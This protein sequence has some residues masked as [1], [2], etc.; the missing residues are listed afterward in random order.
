[1]SD[2][3]KD[4]CKTSKWFYLMIGLIIVSG[5]FVTASY[6]GYF[7]LVGSILGAIFLTIALASIGLIFWTAYKCFG[8]S[9]GIFGIEKHKPDMYDEVFER[10]WLGAGCVLMPI[11]LIIIFNH[12][13]LNIDWIVR[14]YSLG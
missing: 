11:F 14:V 3:I 5:I 4:C 8:L 7:D 10:F 1:M 9:C 2:K 12:I 6:H 13:A